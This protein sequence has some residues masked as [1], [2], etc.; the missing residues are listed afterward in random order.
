MLLWCVLFKTLII[1]RIIIATQ[2]QILIWIIYGDF[3]IKLVSHLHNMTHYQASNLKIFGTRQRPIFHKDISI[4]VLEAY[5]GK[6]VSK[7]YWAM[8]HYTCI[9]NTYI[10]STGL[11]C[12]DSYHTCIKTYRLAMPCHTLS[13]LA[14]LWLIW[15]WK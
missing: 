14:L 9:K 15:T 1:W 7:M 4:C 5:L 8:W 10:S 12:Y 2:I 6:M 11:P 13:R 3:C